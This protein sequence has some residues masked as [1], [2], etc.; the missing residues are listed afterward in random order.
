MTKNL[1]IVESPA[2]AKTISKYLDNSY[3]VRASMGHVVDLPKNDLGVDIEH[4]FKPTYI[5]SKDKQK[6]VTELKK[7][8]KESDK[9]WLATDEDRE[10]EAIAWHILH[11]L[12][13][14]NDDYERI[15]FHEITKD[16]ILKSIK[17]P[18]KI[19]DQL[20]DAQQAR[21]I[22]DRLVGYKLSPLL[23]KKVQKGLSAGRVQSVAVR[24]VVEREEEI[25]NFKPEEYWKVK[26]TAQYNKN[27]V[28]PILLDK[29]KNKKVKLT[30]IDTVKA[31][32][33]D[34]FGN[35]ETLETKT[36]DDFIQI[37]SKI[38]ADTMLL[39]KAVDK[40]LSKKSPAAPFTTSTLQQEAHRKFGFAVAHTMS[41]AQ[42]LYEGV[43][44]EQGRIGLIT[45]MRTDS[46]NLADESLA[47][48]KDYILKNFGK[49]YEISAPRKYKTKSKGAQEAHE[50]IRPVNIFVTPEDVKDVLTPAQLK[51]YSLIWK[52]TVA[53]QMPEAQIE[54]TEVRLLLEQNQNLEFLASG[55][56]I[57]FDGFMKLYIEDTD[58]EPEEDDEALLPSL[59]EGEK[60]VLLDLNSI[61]NYTKPPA[62][63]TE[64]S[65]V[66]KLE[67]EG[68][69]RPST[70]APTISTV[71]N[72]G[73]IEKEK[74]YLKPTE[75]AF[76]VNKFLMEYF[77]DIVDYKFTANIEEEFDDVA[78]G[79]KNWIDIVSKFYDPFSKKLDF[80][81]KNA[82]KYAEETDEK[83]PSCGGQLTIKMSKFGKFYSCSNFP[84]CRYTRSLD[85]SK[86]ETQEVEKTGE[87]CPDCGKPLIYKQGRFG[88]FIAC[89]NYPECKYTKRQSSVIKAAGCPKCGGDII[90]K[91]TKRG[92]PFF[93]CN[94]YP[95]CDYAVWKKEDIK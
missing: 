21:R 28:F 6:T 2:K 63:Y 54:N 83:C 71:I 58:E 3:T 4:D 80:T 39:I 59:K 51:L 74:K 40:K 12:K 88:K 46:L 11:E 19:D 7:I 81:Y 1:V 57:K 75:L 67:S 5:V 41:L 77:S 13:L 93:G 32:L 38:P 91:R 65:L 47:Q 30:D 49:D 76:I 14:K 89:S 61:Q 45:Y 27:K 10:G 95:N 42:Q 43:D 17:N 36:K 86:N 34:G 69:G 24:F 70:Y 52:R 20:V 56:V 87:D 29:Y 53:T 92:K 50:A 82:K 25:R 35:I 31:I 37:N 48:I 68:I 15:V 78:V 90:E 18:R 8:A 94:K 64:A 33:T 9:V 79:Q 84:E 85:Q 62:R 72:R 16:A 44:L 73:Y 55:K 60:A 23:W 66:K 26:G 22:I